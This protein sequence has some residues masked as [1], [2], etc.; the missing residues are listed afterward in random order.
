MEA[1]LNRLA[2]CPLWERVKILEQ[3]MGIARDCKPIEPP[4]VEMKSVLFTT[5]RDTIEK[6]FYIISTGRGWSGPA[7]RCLESHERDCV[8]IGDHD[9]QAALKLRSELDKFLRSCGANGVKLEE[10]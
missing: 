9:I 3:Q 4:V 6:R 7:S 1:D 5:L 10:D 2:G 8:Y